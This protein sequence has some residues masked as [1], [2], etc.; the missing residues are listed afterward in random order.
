MIS[1]TDREFSNFLG[2][3]VSEHK[4]EL[5]EQVLERRTRFLAVVLEDIY[6]P[7]NA[8]AV[9]RSCDCYGVQDLFVIEGRNEYKVNPYVVRG[10]SKWVDIHKFSENIDN[11]ATCIDDLRA[12][13]YKLV[14]TSPGK[15][16]ISLPEF[17][18]TQKTALFFGT[19][20]TG[21]KDETLS[22]MD[23]VIHIPMQGFTESFN[24]SVS[25]AI[26]LYDLTNK[27]HTSDLDWQLNEEEKEE[28]RLEW[29]KK[30]VRSSE[31]LEKEFL[32]NKEL[33]N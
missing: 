31:S 18:L 6:Q 30:V 23:E 20:E 26:C 27:M 19:E 2:E 32:R 22:K 28:I 16:A 33:E 9:V 1:K 8:S 10:S 17:D 14:G 21:L 15:G 29:Y 12:R 5:I 11:S 24:I 13:G 3:Y 4:R 7:H 25:A